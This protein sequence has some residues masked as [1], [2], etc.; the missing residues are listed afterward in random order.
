MTIQ[1]YAASAIEKSS[2]DLVKIALTLPENKRQWKPLSKGRTALSQLAECAVINEMS[3]QV[4]KTGVWDTDLPV[5]TGREAAAL[6]T[7]EKALCGLR[8]GTTALVS[9]VR[10]TPDSD[11]DRLVTLPWGVAKLADVF[12]MPLWNM[13]YHEGQITYIGTL[14]A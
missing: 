7:F 13:S 14:L 2:E 8:D 4:V 3:A 1:E 12:L 11:L 6:D 9:A 10:A 5:S